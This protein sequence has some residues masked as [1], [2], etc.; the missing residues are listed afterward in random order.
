MI[1]NLVYLYWEPI[2][3]CLSLLFTQHR[4]EIAA[5]TERVTGGNPSF[6]SMSYS[7]LWNTWAAS[8]NDSLLA[9]VQNLRS[10]YEIPAC[11]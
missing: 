6:E 5:L 1:V 11:V 7:E 8:G 2:D 10:R 3:A 4:P 9:R